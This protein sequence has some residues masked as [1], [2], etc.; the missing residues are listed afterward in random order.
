MKYIVWLDEEIT[1]KIEVEAESEEQALE[2][3][4][5][6]DREKY[7]YSSELVN[8]QVEIDKMRKVPHEKQRNKKF[9]M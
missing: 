2:I 8:T 3:A 1:Y 7:S 9:N 6:K 5:S 4:L